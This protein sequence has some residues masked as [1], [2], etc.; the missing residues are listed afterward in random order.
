MIGKL[1]IMFF[2]IITFSCTNNLKKE[3]MLLNSQPINIPIELF[4]TYNGI[5]TIINELFD[6]KLKYVVYVDSSNCT[7]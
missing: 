5:D 2:C 1:I 4:V 6:S 3:M 7:S